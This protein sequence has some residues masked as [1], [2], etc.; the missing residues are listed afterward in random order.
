MQIMPSGAAWTNPAALSQQASGDPKQTA[1]Q[2]SAASTQ[3]PV[4]P[5]EETGKTTDRDANERYDGPQHQTGQANSASPESASPLL[6][7]YVRRG[8]DPA[9]LAAS[10]T[11]APGGR[12]VAA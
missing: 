7:L 12:P 1:A 2:K 5:L 4:T 6:L 3:D 10:E 8:A 9:S 11:N